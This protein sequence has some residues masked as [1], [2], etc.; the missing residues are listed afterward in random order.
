MQTGSQFYQ[1]LWLLFECQGF[2]YIVL[3]TEVGG[4]ET[5]ISDN[6]QDDSVYQ[7][8][9]SDPASATAN[10]SDDVTIGQQVSL[11]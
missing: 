7:N 1:L 5:G 3:L 8:V 2:D 6:A 11:Y 4:G 9:D 10:Q